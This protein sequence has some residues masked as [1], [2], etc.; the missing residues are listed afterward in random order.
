MFSNLDGKRERPKMDEGI[1]G[2]LKAL[3]WMIDIVLM[4][5]LEVGL[6]PSIPSILQEVDQDQGIIKIVKVLQI[7]IN[8]EKV[9]QEVFVKDLEAG[10]N[11]G[12]HLNQAI[13]QQ[14][15]VNLRAVTIAQEVESLEAAVKTE[16]TKTMKR[17]LGVGQSDLRRKL[18]RIYKLVKCCC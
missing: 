10:V 13:K 17:D 14:G 18:V 11:L 2:G 16:S 8:L 4:V 1:G 15:E 3:K 5:V 12:I 6:D 9:I 7:I